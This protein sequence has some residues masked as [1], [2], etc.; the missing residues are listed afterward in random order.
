[1]DDS[2]GQVIK[3]GE[4]N[5]TPVTSLGSYSR[6]EPGEI[7]GFTSIVAVDRA[8]AAE[9]AVTYPTWIKHKPEILNSPLIL[10]I[11]GQSETGFTPSQVFSEFG[12]IKARHRG[13]VRFIYWQWPFPTVT[14]MPQRERMLSAL[15]FAMGQIRNL[16]PYWLKIDTDTI[17]TAGGK[18][19]EPVWFLNDPA[20]VA[21]PWGYS[22]PADAID[23]LDAWAATLPVDWKKPP[24]EYH[25]E[26]GARRVHHPRII[27][28]LCFVRSDFAQACTRLICQSNHY[29]D[30]DRLPVPSQDTV[31]GYIAERMGEWVIKPK[32]KHLGWD[33][34]NLARLKEIAGVVS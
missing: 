11:D 31:H 25:P 19:I 23:R 28:W 14:D 24:L 5:R 34:C 16:H 29:H 3:A 8:H 4:G 12:Y 33:H 22:K 30:T 18:W 1:M 9:L 21:S 13:D 26:P 6:W 2:N 7:P 17:A 15:V 27:S 10:I 20:L 32:M